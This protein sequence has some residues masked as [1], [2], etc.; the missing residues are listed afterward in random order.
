MVLASMR[1][2]WSTWLVIQLVSVKK[3][4]LAIEVL[5]LNLQAFPEHIESYLCLA[6]LHLRE[7][8]HARAEEFRL[9]ALSI[10]PGNP[11]VTELLASVR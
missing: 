8:K 6:K 10:S 3:I 11:A 9:K 5:G 4:E 7:G 1:T 2:T